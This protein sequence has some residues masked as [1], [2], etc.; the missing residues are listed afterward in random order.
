MADS[1]QELID[2]I[3]EMGERRR[4]ARCA[5]T[6]CESD[7]LGTWRCAY[8]P[9]TIALHDND[10]R[11]GNYECCDLSPDPRSKDYAVRRSRRGCT[12]CDHIEFPDMYLADDMHM[13][14]DIAR[15]FLSDDLLQAPGIRIDH[16]RNS[17][18]ISRVSRESCFY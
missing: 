2:A 1:E 4:C 17:V 9:G 13:N 16:S 11:T 3:L 10:V 14:L 8:H 6:Y 5:E 12:P 18:L 15:R 7:N